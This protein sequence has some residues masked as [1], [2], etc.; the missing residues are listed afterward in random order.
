MVAGQS[1]TEILSLHDITI[2]IQCRAPKGASDFER[3]S[4]SLKR[5]PDTNLNSLLRAWVFSYEPGFFRNWL[6]HD[7]AAPPSFP[8]FDSRAPGNP[9]RCSSTCLAASCSARFLVAPW[10][11]PTNC[12]MAGAGNRTSTVK[13][14]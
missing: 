11:R 6:R 14:F 9:A 5:Y 2:G 7:Y 3:L 13:V 4:V 10:A 1:P 8:P 12:P